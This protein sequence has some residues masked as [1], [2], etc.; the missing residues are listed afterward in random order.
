MKMGAP[1]ER[2]PLESDHKNNKLCRCFLCAFNLPQGEIGQSLFIGRLSKRLGERCSGDLMH[3]GSTQ[4]ISVHTPSY[5]PTG[6]FTAFS[7]RD[8]S[9]H[10]KPFG[11]D[12][13]PIPNRPL[14]LSVCSSASI[15]FRTPVS[16]LQP[17]SSSNFTIVLFIKHNLLCIFL[18][19]VAPF[20]RANCE[21]QLFAINERPLMQYSQRYGVMP[22]ELLHRRPVSLTFPP[23]L[24]IALWQLWAV[25]CLIKIEFGVFKWAL[26][27]STRPIFLRRPP[28]S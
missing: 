6:H 27:A 2:V 9:F 28:Q 10:Q 7:L 23:F 11:V 4:C 18:Q 21:S 13:L 15:P 5:I 24:W 26:N 3:S 17:L 1:L 20:H 19:F 25:V 22:C 12:F 8:K 14:M 16:S